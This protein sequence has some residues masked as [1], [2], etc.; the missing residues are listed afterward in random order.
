ML[1]AT[2]AV[3][4][5]VAYI[6]QGE[7]WVRPLAGGPARRLAAGGEYHSPEW[8]P[9]GQH[10]LVHQGQERWLLEADGSR[11]YKLP[12]DLLVT[13]WS[14]AADL[15]AYSDR[16][17]RIGV[18]DVGGRRTVLAEPRPGEGFGGPIWS[19]DGGWIAYWAGSGKPPGRGYASIWR[20]SVT[21]EQRWE[22]YATREQ[23]TPCFELAAWTLDDQAILYWSRPGCSASIA[24]DGLPLMVMPLDGS[25]H[26]VVADG[27]LLY[28][29]WLSF[30]ADGAL[31]LV[32][33][34]GR[35]AWAGK[36]VA[37]ASSWREGAVAVTPP[38]QAAVSPAWAPGG[39]RIAYAGAPDAGGA[40][41]GEAARRA[42][43]KRRI[44]LVGR[45]GSA[46]SQLTQDPGYRDE[47]PRWSGDG[48]RILFGRLDERGSKAGLWS[49][50]AAG[51]RAM[52]VL[53]TAVDPPCG[54][55]DWFGYYGHCPWERVVSLWSP[56]QNRRRS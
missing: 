43:L 27:T 48:S 36:R 17:G 46:P 8:S 44:W 6:H 34:H 9:S 31:A 7:L 42:L 12:D 13:R 49:I 2:P 25:P 55:Q 3:G 51:G 1:A 4:D 24:A 19:Q 45:D 47:A 18:M 16:A 11:G 40:G 52:P 22:L 14:P 50:K 26:R 56:A 37:V 54:E 30:A 35:Q 53:I 32:E 41:G 5:Q 33:G 20:V 28:A 29:E 39:D 23:P 15:L 38:D 10:L 21:G